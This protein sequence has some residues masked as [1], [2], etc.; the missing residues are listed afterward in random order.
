MIQPAAQKMM[1]TRAAPPN[2]I[3]F[4]KASHA[5]MLSHPEELAKFIEQ[6][7]HHSALMPQSA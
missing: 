2:H 7:A 5:P 6:A 4:I 1:A 3:I